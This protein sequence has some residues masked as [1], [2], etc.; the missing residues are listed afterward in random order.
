LATHQNK[1]SDKASSPNPVLAERRLFL[2]TWLFPAFLAEAVFEL[3]VDT[4][5]LALRDIDLTPALSSPDTL[6]C[7]PRNYGYL[8][9]PHQKAKIR[10]ESLTLTLLTYLYHIN[11]TAVNANIAECGRFRQNRTSH[12]SYSRRKQGLQIF[13]RSTRSLVFPS[14]ESDSSQFCCDGF[15]KASDD[16]GFKTIHSLVGQCAVLISET[17]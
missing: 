17:K 1:T 13:K 9:H 3:Q 2:R 4:H 12:S 14:Y 8:T 10:K 6:K 16:G 7:L 5:T 15:G 11:Y